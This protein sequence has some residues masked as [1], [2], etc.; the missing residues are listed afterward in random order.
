MAAIYSCEPNRK[1][2]LGIEG[3]SMYVRK[4]SWRSVNSYS[5]RSHPATAAIT[6]FEC[7]CRKIRQI[8]KSECLS[9]RIP[10]TSGSVNVSKFLDITA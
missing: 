3:A 6:E 10:I 9:K 5:S 4:L 2:A 8:H 1:E 7:I